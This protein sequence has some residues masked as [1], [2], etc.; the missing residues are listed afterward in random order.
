[1]RTVRQSLTLPV[2]LASQVR[3]MA[4][5][6]RLSAN[7]MMVELIEKGVEAERRKK[8]EFAALAKRFREASDPAEAERLGDQLGRMIFGG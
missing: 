6:R 2:P 8:L 1:M 5:S 7:R 4:K 3:G